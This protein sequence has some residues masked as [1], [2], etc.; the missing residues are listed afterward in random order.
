[1][2]GNNAKKDIADHDAAQNDADVNERG[3]VRQELGGKPAQNQDEDRN[4]RGKQSGP[5]RQGTADEPLIQGKTARDQPEA[6]PNGLR[7]LGHPFFHADQV[8]ITS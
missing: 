4:E 5:A 1:M 8:G 6:H 3:S 7:R 2:R